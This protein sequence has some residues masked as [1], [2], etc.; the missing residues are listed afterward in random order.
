MVAAAIHLGLLPS[1]RVPAAREIEALPYFDKTSSEEI[2]TC[3]FVGRDECDREVY[4]MGMGSNRQVVKRAILSILSIFGIDAGEL[5]LIDALPS[6]GL[7]VRVGGILSRRL[8]LIRAGRPL[9]IKGIQR[10][11]R[12]FCDFVKKAKESL[13][14]SQT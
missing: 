7:L 3:F 11:Y 10:N 8:G 14:S 4:V 6:A 2:G 5:A 13:T 12:V 9:A 1:D